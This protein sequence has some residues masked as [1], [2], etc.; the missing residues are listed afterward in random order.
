MVGDHDVDDERIACDANDA[1]SEVEDRSD[2][3]EDEPCEVVYGGME[4]WCGGGVGVVGEHGG[5]V[6]DDETVVAGK[7]VAVVV[8]VGKGVFIVVEAVGVIVVVVE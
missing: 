7:G 4:G 8:V 1:N 6:E 2:D 5:C 3:V